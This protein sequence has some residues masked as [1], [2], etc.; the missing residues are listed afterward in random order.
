MSGN[1][2]FM[3]DMLRRIKIRHNRREKRNN[4]QKLSDDFYNRPGMTKQDKISQSVYSIKEKLE[5]Y[6]QIDRE[7]YPH[8]PPG[9]F[10]RYLKKLPND[11]IKYCHGGLLAINA[12]PKYWILK[13]KTP[14]GTFKTWSVQL[15][16]DNMYFCKKH[17]SV[18]EKSL[19]E[20]CEMVMSG[21]YRLVKADL[22][23]KLDPRILIELVGKE[24]ENANE[25]E[26]SDEESST[27]ESDDD[28]D[29]LRR[30]TTI[31]TLMK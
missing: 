15:Q 3:E 25:D 27:M 11:R 21:K 16:N 31:V 18:P 12:Y 28:S 29:E 14:D 7:D 19:Q 6:E 23:S 24:D 17:D 8:I 2:Q 20:I 9:T 13:N 5:D 22:L 4:N 10:I 1:N 30:G 26:N